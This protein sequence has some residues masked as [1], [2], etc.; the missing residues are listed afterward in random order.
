[1]ECLTRKEIEEL[2]ELDSEGKFI[3]L[4]IPDDGDKPEL[5]LIGTIHTELPAEQLRRVKIYANKL[6]EANLCG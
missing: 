1:M 3:R 6:I 4:I 5:N 2:F